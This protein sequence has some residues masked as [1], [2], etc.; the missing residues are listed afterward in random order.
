M[1][2]IVFASSKGGAGKTTAAFVLATVAAHHGTPTTLIDADPNQP[3]AKWAAEN[4]GH[5]A[6][7]LQIVSALGDMVMDAI[8]NSTS[9]LTIVDLEGSKNQDVSVGIGRADLVLIPMTGSRLDA[10]E[11]TS[12][13]R[14]IKRQEIAFRRQIPYR[15]LLTRLSAVVMDRQTKDI[16][17]Q[18]KNAGIPMLNS[19]LVERAA[20][21]AMFHLGRNLYEMTEKDVS[22]PEAA[23]ENAETL[24]AEVHTVLASVL[25]PAHV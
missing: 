8:D 2:T 4:T 6:N 7:N 20:Y 13:I 11:A 3:L 18:F 25:E 17:S 15:L 1:A 12:V 10:N 24:V 5:V 21:K 22:K 23:I 16:I 9:S 19:I 14:V